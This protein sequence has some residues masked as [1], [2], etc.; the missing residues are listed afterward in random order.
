[1]NQRRY[2]PRTR[3]ALAAYLDALGVSPDRFSLYGRSDADDSYV[4]DKRPEGWVVF[5]AERGG[6]TPITVYENE[7]DACADMLSRVSNDL[8]SLCHLIAGP[9]PKSEADEAFDD[10]LRGFGVTRDDLRPE[11]WLYDDVPWVEGPYWRRYFI[12]T[13]T[14]RR[15]FDSL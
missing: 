1:M 8:Y 13:T 9:A 15:L 14:A 3:L 6:K 11:D 10:W 7:A 2:E 12:R 4:L 5:Y